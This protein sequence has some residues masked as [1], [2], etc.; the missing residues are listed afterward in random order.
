M[1]L[2]FTRPSPQMAE[3]ARKNKVNLDDPMVIAEFKKIQTQNLR[4]IQM[5]KDGK[6]P[7][8]A[9]ELQQKLIEDR[10]N[11]FK[12]KMEEYERKNNES[13][14][15]IEEFK[16]LLQNQSESTVDQLE[17]MKEQV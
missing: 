4:D 7:P 14:K 3:F 17:K 8:T 15:K 2:D 13:E 16:H 10:E 6:R 9:E 1:N 11:E 12:L 5:M